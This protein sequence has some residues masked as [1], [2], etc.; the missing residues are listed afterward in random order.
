MDFIWN[1][2]K[3]AADLLVNGDPDILVVVGTTLKVAL[4]SPVLAL[5]IGLP[6]GLA[7][8]L[9]RFRG[10]RVGLAF[11][12]AGRGRPPVVGGLVAARLLFRGAPLGGLN[13]LYTVNGVIAAQTLLALPLVAALTA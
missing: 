9:G 12:N 1:G 8:G 6:I 10:R 4:W 7:L 3:Q 2:L 5:A 13:L 11:A